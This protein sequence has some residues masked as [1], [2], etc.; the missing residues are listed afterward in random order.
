MSATILVRANNGFVRPIITIRLLC[1]LCS[2]VFILMMWTDSFVSC[3]HDQ[4]SAF[5]AYSVF[6][7]LCEQSRLGV[8][9]LLPFQACSS[10]LYISFLNSLCKPLLRIFIKYS[11]ATHQNGNTETNAP[12]HEP[13]NLKRKKVDAI[14]WN[15]N[16][17][18]NRF[19][20][21]VCRGQVGERSCSTPHPMAHARVR[22]V[23]RPQLM[24]VVASTPVRC[25]VSDHG[26]FQ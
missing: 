22:C 19:N 13:N 20:Q 25:S 5:A 15:A 16:L 24:H 1:R 9:G 14:Y 26:A 21:G 18:G 17:V 8:C 7:C 3:V 6:I 2:G 11:S 10:T 23:C 4:M 12:V